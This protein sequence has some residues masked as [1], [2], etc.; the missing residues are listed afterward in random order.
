MA[1]KEKT[2]HIRIRA[3]DRDAFREVPLAQMDIGCMGG[4]RPQADGTF[5]LE[6]IV[7]ETL[8]KKLKADRHDV[9]VLAD[10]AEQ[11]KKKPKPV[12][13]GNRFTGADSIPRGLGRKI[14]EGEKP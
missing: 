4:I 9:R 14:R 3:K 7:S 8:L 6:A 11:E 5:A 12:A 13:P 2:Y 1:G 10:I